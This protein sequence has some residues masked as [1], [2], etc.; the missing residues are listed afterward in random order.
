MIQQHEGLADD[1]LWGVA[2]IAAYI[3]RS[4]RQTYYLIA[5]GLPAKKIGR[6]IIM[7]RRHELDAYLRNGGIDDGS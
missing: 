6:K 3:N 4:E 1:V 2:A 7:A 5:K